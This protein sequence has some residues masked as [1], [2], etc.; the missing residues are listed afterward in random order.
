MTE[1]D[2]ET[3]KKETSWI[4]KMIKFVVNIIIYIV[5]GIIYLWLGEF[6]LSLLI[7]IV[8]LNHQDVSSPQMLILIT[9]VTSSLMTG[10]LFTIPIHKWIKGL[11]YKIARFID[12]KI[13]SPKKITKTDDSKEESSDEEAETINE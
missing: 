11:C 13:T 4:R 5:T 1:K 7:N 10:V 2:I 8:N 9:G 12:K 3:V 6:I